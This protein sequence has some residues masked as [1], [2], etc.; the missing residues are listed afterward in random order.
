MVYNIDIHQLNIGK[1]ENLKF[2]D[3][4]PLKKCVF[5]HFFSNECIIYNIFFLGKKTIT[6]S[7]KRRFYRWALHCFSNFLLFGNVS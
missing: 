6:I 4:I 1:F 2:L 5:L 3:E 7:K